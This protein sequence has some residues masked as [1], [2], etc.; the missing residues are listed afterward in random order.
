MLKRRRADR[1]G[2]ERLLAHRLEVRHVHE[3]HFTGWLTLL[4]LDSVTEPMVQPLAGRDYRLAADGYLWLQHFPEGER[5]TVTTLFDDRRQV[6]QWYI[7]ICEATGL[8]EDG[9]PWFDD[10]YLDI[11]ILPDGEWHVLDVDELDEALA[12]GIVSQEQYDRAHG[13]LQRLLNRLRS[14][15]MPLLALTPAHLERYFPPAE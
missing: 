9:V 2:W 10:L 4:R 6:I 1:A 8:D 7:D 15:R 11:A 12:L 5:Y 3:S 13:E 14:G